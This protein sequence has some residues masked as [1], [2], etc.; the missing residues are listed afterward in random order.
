VASASR[1]AEGVQEKEPELGMPTARGAPR[2]TTLDEG[3]RRRIRETVFLVVGSQVIWKGLQAG[4]TCG[5]KGQHGVSF[6][7]ISDRADRGQDSPR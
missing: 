7:F 2:G 1:S 6:H 3:P 4:T 5:E